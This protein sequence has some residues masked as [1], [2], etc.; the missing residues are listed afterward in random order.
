M[1]LNLTNA[2][3]TF[4][5]FVNNSWQEYLNLYCN[6]NFHENLIDNQD[7]LKEH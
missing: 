6:T 4:Q 5:Y 3:V 2:L 7:P 1:P